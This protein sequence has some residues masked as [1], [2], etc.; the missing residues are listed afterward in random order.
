M[1]KIS[2]LSYKNKTATFYISEQVKKYL[3][4]VEELREKTK[5]TNHNK[6]VWFESFLAEHHP[7]CDECK[8]TYVSV[9]DKPKGEKTQKIRDKFVTFTV[10]KK[11][12]SKPILTA[13]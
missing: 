4:V 3:G 12:Q 10:K 9:H 5:D 2:V 1:E 11:R 8:I 6:W 13:R 7:K